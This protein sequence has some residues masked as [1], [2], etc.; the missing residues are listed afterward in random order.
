METPVRFDVAKALHRAPSSAHPGLGFY[1]YVDTWTASADQRSWTF[2][3]GKKIEFLEKIRALNEALAKPG[4]AGSALLE[5]V[6]CRQERLLAALSS[7]AYVIGRRTMNTSWRLVTGLGISHP[8][9]N[10]FVFH[11]TWGVPYLP[12]SGVKGA[13]SGWARESEDRSQAWGHRAALFGQPLDEKNDP[14]QAGQVIFFDALPTVWPQI[15]ID[16]VNPHYGDY[17][18]GKSS[19]ADWLDPNPVHFLAIAPG[20]PFEF[21]FAVKPQG[22]DSTTGQQELLT[23]ATDAL[24]GAAT[25]GGMGGKSGVGYGYFV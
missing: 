4:G 7:N 16:I 8:L 10:G 21:V 2:E 19:P 12:G 15:D 5:S 18:Q 1:K 9:E 14:P 25:E 23:L 20:Q 22:A 13:A 17:Y 11:H 24:V 6:R 3:D